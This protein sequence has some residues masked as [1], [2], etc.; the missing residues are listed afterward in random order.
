MR[1]ALFLAVILTAPEAFAVGL[2]DAGR[3]GR[4]ASL[5]AAKIGRQAEVRARALSGKTQSADLSILF[6]LGAKPELADLTG[7]YSGRRFTKTGPSATLLVGGELYA[8]PARGP[9]GGKSFKVVLFGGGAPG[10]SPADLYDEPGTHTIDTVNFLLPER[11]KDYAPIQFTESGAV[12]KKGADVY[13]FRKW[14]R[15][16]IVKYPDEGYGYFFKKLTPVAGAAAKAAKDAEATPVPAPAAPATPPAGPSQGIL[17][18]PGS[19]ELSA[20]FDAGSAPS[21]GRLSGWFAGRRYTKEGPVA[22]LLCGVELYD[23]PA[24][25]PIDGSTF[26]LVLFGPDK[27]GVVPAELYDLGGSGMINGVAWNLR[28]RLPRWTTTRQDTGVVTSNAGESFEVRES[29]EF[30]VVRYPQ[31]FG[32]FFKKIR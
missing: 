1:K 20:L 9:I 26:K 14:G 13:E 6:D 16:L 4:Q 18:L 31:A 28:E 12:L 22:A 32:Y 29:G 24:A 8:D 23:N 25:G 21:E 27:S 11:S 2:E 10:T 19:Q 30:L 5:E 3:L 7:W 15:Y 17:P